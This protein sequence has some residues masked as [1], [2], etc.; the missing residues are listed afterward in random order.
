M[1][2]Q[3]DCFSLYK[4]T[5]FVEELYTYKEETYTMTEGESFYAFL[6]IY[7]KWVIIYINSWTHRNKFNRKRKN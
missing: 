1:H 6:L 5:L 3:T 7:E 2:N 4:D